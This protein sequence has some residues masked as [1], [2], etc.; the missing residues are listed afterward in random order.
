MVLPCVQQAQRR[1]LEEQ[2]AANPP[3]KASRGTAAG[4]PPAAA[5]RQAVKRAAPAPEKIPE[6]VTA[7]EVEMK[8]VS[9]KAVAA[10]EQSPTAAEAGAADTGAGDPPVVAEAAEAQAGVPDTEA[11]AQVRKENCNT[12]LKMWGRQHPAWRQRQEM[13]KNSSSAGSRQVAERNS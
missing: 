2:Y 7:L 8:A 1:I 6:A 5:P 4:V 3:A 9:P 11:D 10:F 13:D 12:M